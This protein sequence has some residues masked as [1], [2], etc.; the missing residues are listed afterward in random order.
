MRKFLLSMAIIGLCGV[1]ASAQQDKDPA[2]YAATEAGEQLTNLYLNSSVLHDGAAIYP[3]GIAGD[4]RG[5]A[6][7]NGKMYVCNRGAGGVSQL[8]ELDGVTGALLRT[9]ELPKEMWQ[10]E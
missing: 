9:I 7:A 8:V 3:G 4:A 10:E 1:T 6:V 2:V 5:M